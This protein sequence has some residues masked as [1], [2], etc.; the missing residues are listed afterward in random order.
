MTLVFKDQYQDCLETDNKF[1]RSLGNALELNEWSDFRRQLTRD[2]PSFRVELNKR[3]S[4]RTLFEISV[5]SEFG[6]NGTCVSIE[7]R[8]KFYS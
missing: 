5:F 1:N 8:S 3:R 6:M 4:N 7:A 2:W